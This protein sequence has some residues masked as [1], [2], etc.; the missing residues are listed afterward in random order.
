[1]QTYPYMQS[2]QP[3]C[4]T[5]PGKLAG[6][7]IYSL[8]W[9]VIIKNNIAYDN[10]SYTLYGYDI[11][12][13]TGKDPHSYPGVVEILN[14]WTSSD[15]NP[16]FINPDVSDPTSTVLPDLTLQSDSGAI[17]KGTHLT[18]AVGS[19]KD[20]VTLYVEDAMYF[21]DGSWG[22]DL[23]RGK[24][25]FPDWIAIGSTD[26]VAE[27]ESIDYSSNLIKLKRHLTWNDGDKIWL[28]RKS[29]GAVVLYGNSPDLGAHE[30][31]FN[32]PTD[33]GLTDVSENTEDIIIPEDSGFTGIDVAEDNIAT[34]AEEKDLTNYDTEDIIDSEDRK[35][36]DS[37]VMDSSESDYLE[38]DKDYVS[39]D[40]DNAMTDIT[41][42]AERTDQ[43]DN[44]GCSCSTIY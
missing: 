8:A 6:I 34:D 41:G 27:I 1:R 25:M 31:I 42:A 17:D 18:I 4:S 12:V 28:Y 33:G 9:D 32:V 5:C 23:A 14:N 39:L 10:Y 26:N 13:D 7:N 22:S 30:V 11:T 15:G 35:I 21:Q 43:K 36:S 19:G 44:T 3:G 38:T 16:K 2:S 24:T 20:S 37:A 29:D 40:S